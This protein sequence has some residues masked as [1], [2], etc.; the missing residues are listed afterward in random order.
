MEPVGRTVLPDADGVAVA[1]AIN[2]N[3]G[4]RALVLDPSGRL[5]GMVTAEGLMNRRSRTRGRAFR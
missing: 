2:A 3:G 4:Q 1:E 5:R